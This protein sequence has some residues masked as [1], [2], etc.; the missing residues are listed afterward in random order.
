MV[1]SSNTIEP[2]KQAYSGSCHCGHVKY[3]IWAVMK[4]IDFIVQGSASGPKVPP[5][6][7]IRIYKC[8]CTICHKLG[9]FHV[10]LNDAANDFALLSPLDPINELKDYRC[11]RGVTHFLFCKECGVTCFLFG[12]P[13]VG[14]VVTRTDIPGQEGEEVKVWAPSKTN[15]TENGSHEERKGAYLSINAHSIDPGQKGFDLREWVEKKQVVY[16]DALSELE[17]DNFDRPAEGGTY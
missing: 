13:G 16:I 2:K 1:E 3:I 5:A 9:Q 10:R 15:W 6:T 7:G 8:N 14:E 4:P 17:E 12:G 11:N